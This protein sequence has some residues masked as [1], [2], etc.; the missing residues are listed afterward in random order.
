MKELC[1]KMCFEQDLPFLE[2]FLKEMLVVEISTTRSECPMYR[3]SLKLTF[4]RFDLAEISICT[5]NQGSSIPF[6]RTK[7]FA[8]R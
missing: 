4:T 1:I 8:E 6:S 3:A 2:T 7:Y 5:D